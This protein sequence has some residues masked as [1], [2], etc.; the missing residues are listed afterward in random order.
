MAGAMATQAGARCIYTRAS[1][2][3][4]DQCTKQLHSSMHYARSRPSANDT[5]PLHTKQQC[6]C[7]DD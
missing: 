1:Y 5:E 6:T 2:G 3:L 4:C 7:R